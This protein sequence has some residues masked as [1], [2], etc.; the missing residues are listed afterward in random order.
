MVGMCKDDVNCG[1]SGG[2]ETR[3]RCG[4]EIL[5]GMAVK[6]NMGLCM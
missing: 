5:F 1:S 6:F 3:S 2:S 4:G